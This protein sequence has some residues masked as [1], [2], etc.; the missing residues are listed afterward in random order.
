[1]FSYL[2]L[3]RLFQVRITFG[4]CLWTSF[5]DLIGLVLELVV[6]CVNCVLITTSELCFECKIAVG[7]GLYCWWFSCLVLLVFG[8]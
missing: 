5:D 4:G 2:D 1:M 6:V 7:L 8:G 3:C